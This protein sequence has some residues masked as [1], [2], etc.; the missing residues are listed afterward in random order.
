MFLF[1][2]Y[3]STIYAVD[4]SID[5]TEM[6]EPYYLHLK[7]DGVTITHYIN[8]AETEVFSTQT[9]TDGTVQLTIAVTASVDGSTF[10]FQLDSTNPPNL[11]IIFENPQAIP[12]TIFFKGWETFDKSIT[13]SFQ[14][15]ASISLSGIPKTANAKVVNSEGQIYSQIIPESI[16]FAVCYNSF[17]CSSQEGFSIQPDETY[18]SNLNDDTIF[19]VSETMEGIEIKTLKIYY[20]QDD[21]GENYFPGFSPYDDLIFNTIEIIGLST[22]PVQVNF[23][24][25]EIIENVEVFTFQ[26]IQIVS[27]YEEPE[28]SFNEVY[29]KDGINVFPTSSIIT[30]KTSHENRKNSEQSPFQ[31]INGIEHSIFNIFPNFETNGDVTLTINANEI[32]ITNK[33]ETVIATVPNLGSTSRSIYIDDQKNENKNKI[34]IKLGEG[35]EKPFDI[36]VENSDQL[37]ID[38]V[39]FT[40]VQASSFVFDFYSNAASD[41]TINNNK[42]YYH[43]YNFDMSLL[44]SEYPAVA[45]SFV[46]CLASDEC[47]LP[48]FGSSDVL[49]IPVQGDADSSITSLY[50]QLQGISKIESITLILN[51]AFNGKIFDLAPHIQGSSLSKIRFICTGEKSVAITLNSLPNMQ[52]TDWEVRNCDLT[53]SSQDQYSIDE[54]TLYDSKLLNADKITIKRTNYVKSIDLTK[55]DFVIT[56]SDT[57]F[58]FNE[59][60]VKSPN[61]LK[62]IVKTGESPQHSIIFENKDSIKNTCEVEVEIE[63]FDKNNSNIPISTSEKWNTL[64]A[65]SIKPIK[66]NVNSEFDHIILKTLP[67]NINIIVYYKGENKNLLLSQIPSKSSQDHLIVCYGNK[68]CS[69]SPNFTVSDDDI[70]ISTKTEQEF[71]DLM[72]LIEKQPDKKY[73][74]LKLAFI[75]DKNSYKVKFQE[76]PSEKVD[77]LQ[78]CGYIDYETNDYFTNI[79]LSDDVETKDIGNLYLKSVRFLIDPL[80]TKSFSFNDVT[81][82]GTSSVFQSGKIDVDVAR[83]ICK[84]GNDLT[85]FNKIITNIKSLIFDVCTDLETKD[86]IMTLRRNVILLN[87]SLE[88]TFQ[89]T[90]SIPEP[91]NPHYYFVIHGSSESNKKLII[92]RLE[93]TFNNISIIIENSTKTVPIEFVCESTEINKKFLIN[94]YKLN[95]NEVSINQG[96]CSNVDLKIIPY[97]DIPDQ[98]K[99]ENSE[100]SQNSEDDLSSSEILT[101]S[102]TDENTN[103]PEN[104]IDSDSSIFEITSNGFKEGDDQPEHSINKDPNIINTIT[105]TQPE[106]IIKEESSLSSTNPLYFVASNENSLIKIDKNLKNS[107]IGIT[108]DKSP[109]VEVSN[110]D[111]P[112][113]FMNDISDGGS[114]TI[115]IPSTETISQLNLREVNNKKGDFSL[116]VPSNIDFVS[117]IKLALSQK[118]SFSISPSL[119][120]NNEMLLA[121]ENGVKVEVKELIDISPNS[122][123]TL[124]NVHLQQ[125]L[126]IYDDSKLTLTKNSELLTS[127]IVDVIIQNS[128]VYSTSKPLIL[129]D[130]N[131]KNSPKSII[132]SSNDD[133]LIDVSNL[134]LIGSEGTFEKCNELKNKIE[135]ENGKKGTIKSECKSKDGI[136]SLYVTAKENKDDGKEDEKK[137]LSGGEIAGIVIACIVVVAAI[138]LLAVFLTRRKRHYKQQEDNSDISS[139]KI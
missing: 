83:L 27:D 118:S 38:L 109:K 16:N 72:K 90:N 24:T 43:H 31:N 44:F 106:I 52:K 135:F 121:D 50:S 81:N 12:F 26:N 87:S 19:E 30:V 32:S 79:L 49:Q 113:S 48:E 82:D 63:G 103:Q 53:I 94:Y 137:G 42:V 10:Y 58:S 124:S 101:E 80:S 133:N 98:S 22:D 134:P 131:I 116:F 47:S 61:K 111:V 117:F 23:D 102:L 3:L 138:I 71:S 15:E 2:F 95:G 60:S 8:N 76:I 1:A 64:Q 28:F 56:V 59:V 54:L 34:I 6:L 55:D 57:D 62:L 85:G 40:E 4:C 41:I 74:F 86:Y 11:E 104:N 120:N 115:S 129:F 14:Y 110:N 51:E 46:F 105:F 29:I 128:K 99:S 93:N 122:D 9:I 132:V 73:Q 78:L 97:P 33:D 68:V 18:I 70:L 67:K 123:V 89:S 21:T 69:K 88:N 84:P 77:Q 127:S 39:D 65:G 66:I 100:D 7:D 36:R 45:T 108:T 37:E 91:T 107:N 125:K 119:N 96:S 17:D 35:A 139:I 112:L 126:N 75:G 92:N 5:I 13:F 130:E 114:L 20:I 136:T 25:N